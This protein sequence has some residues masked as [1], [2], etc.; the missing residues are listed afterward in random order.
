MIPAN[1]QLIED[2][3]FAGWEMSLRGHPGSAIEARIE[4]LYFRCIMHDV[5]LLPSALR[6]A[7]S[8]IHYD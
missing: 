5:S 6:R 1:A 4:I 8:F 2:D 7:C 3:C